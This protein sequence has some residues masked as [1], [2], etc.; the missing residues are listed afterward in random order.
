MIPRES[1]QTEGTTLRLKLL[2]RTEVVPMTGIQGEG[3]VSVKVRW[4]VTEKRRERKE[5]LVLF[6]L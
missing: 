5:Y 6:S 3:T 4:K 2:K 1:P